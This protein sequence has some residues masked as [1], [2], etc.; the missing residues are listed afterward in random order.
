M[1]ENKG[2]T[3]QKDLDLIQ[4]QKRTALLRYTLS[5][6]NSFA[7]VTRGSRE[8]DDAGRVELWAKSLFIQGA[9]RCE[10]IEGIDNVWFSCGEMAR[11][12]WARNLAARLNVQAGLNQENLQNV[13]LKDLKD[14]R[15]HDS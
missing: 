10:T 1:I 14:L 5:K 4:E 8:S 9:E 13:V 15:R 2:V 12:N 7:F 3:D 11:E 6:L